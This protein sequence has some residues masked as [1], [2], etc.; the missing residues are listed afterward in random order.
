MPGP[1][2]QEV[3]RH[4]DA[5]AGQHASRAAALAARRSGPLY[6]YKRYANA[7]KRRMIMRYAGGAG[8]TLVDLGCGRGG[9]LGKWREAGLRHVLALDLSAAQ[10]DEA[11]QREARDPPRRQPGTTISWRHGSMGAAGLS[12]E[13]RRELPP[14]G[15]DAVA[16]QFAVH[17]AFGTEAGAKALLAEAASLLRP[18]GVFFG[19]APDADAIEA[20]PP[21]PLTP[22]FSSMGLSL[23]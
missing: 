20:P 16:A 15:A 18:G 7:A 6:A 10:L 8:A 12:A 23:F 14:A 4:Y 21:H 13:L 1:A 11:R 5:Q 17:Y 19:I 2:T 3:E 9:D 22:I